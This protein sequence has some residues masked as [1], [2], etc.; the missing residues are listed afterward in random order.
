MWAITLTA[1]VVMFILDF[2]TTRKPHEVSMREAAAW[3]SFYIA[4]P[5][6][7]G[8]WLWS[9][10][11]ATTGEE[12]LTGYIVEKSLSV[13]N[14]FI[15]MLLLAGFAVPKIYQQRVLL[16]GVAGALIM[17]G[18]MIALGAQLLGNF[19]WMF[20]VFG[21]ILLLSAVKVFRDTMS[22]DEHE[23]DVNDMRLVKAVRRFMPVTND[24]RGTKMVVREAD[25]SGM[26]KRML[27]PLAL[28][29][30][31]VLFTDGVFAIDSV[32]AV[33]GITA[34]PYLVFVTNA[35]ALMGLRAL[36][37]IVEGVLSKLVHLGYGLAL[38][39]AFISYKLIAHWAHGIWHWVPM[40]STALSLSVIVG[41]LV[42]V[43][44]TSLLA[45]RAKSRSH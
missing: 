3:S 9:R 21:L 19:T 30:I 23:I 26:T 22:D 2:I 45:T 31:A 13:D 11:G 34:D 5:L 7:F 16:I 40:P 20:L 43:T 25:S 28:V 35:F 36:Y 42:T 1:V 24:Y 39:L 4:L 41:T 15:F 6:A 33:Y 32:P 29:T 18:I 14:L 12:F 44:V 17:R 37:F 27:T 8:A 10:Y 38:I